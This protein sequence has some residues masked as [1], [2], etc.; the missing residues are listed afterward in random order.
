MNRHLFL[1]IVLLFC[2]STL[3]AQEKQG[4][5]SGHIR[6]GQGPLVGA[7]AFLIKDQSTQEIFRYAISDS[8]GKFSITIPEGDYIL[9][10]SFVGYD[11][12]VKEI[13][14]TSEKLDVGSITLQETT[15]ELQ[16][17]VVRGKAVKVR[18]QP[19]G[20]VVNVKELRERSNDALDLLKLIPRVQ[21]K[22]DQLSVIG[23]D[24]V[25]VKVGNVLQ[26]VEAS[27]IASVLKGYDA[28]LI[29][30]VEVI[31]QPP[32]RYDPDGN[33]AMI[34][35]HTSSIF[36]EYIG[37]VVGTEEMWGGK[38]NFRFGGHGALHYNRRGLFASLAPSIN[39]NGS[40]YS[41]QQ[42]YQMGKY[43]YKVQTPSVG[44]FNYKGIRGNLQ[45][46]YG[47]KK[48]IGWAFSWNGK[49]YNN[50]FE[51]REISS[52]LGDF[53]RV[54]DNENS[55]KS[56]EP[57]LTATAYWE[58]TFGRKGHQVWTE[59][60]YFNLTNGSQTNYVGRELFQNT[61]FLKY[62][63]DNDINTSGLNLNNDYSIYIDSEHKYLLET[64]IKGAWSFTTNYR[65]H[66]E[67]RNLNPATLQS[68]SIRWN[69]LILTPYISSTLR[70]G[71][72]WWMR[73]GL[74]YTGTQSLLQQIG[75]NPT[76]IPKVSMYHDAWLPLL[77]TSYTPSSGH[78][79]TFSFN[80]SIDRP[81]FKDLNPFVWQINENSFYRGNTDLRPQLYY[82]TSLGYTFKRAL[83]IKGRA[84]RGLGLITT[85]S[86]MQEKKIYT[87]M[88]NAQNSLFL[89]LEAGYYLDK[90]SWMSAGIDG[91]YGWSQYTSTH[92]SL[93]PETQ[94]REWGLSGYLDITFNKNRTWTGYI[95]GEYT[96]RKNTTVA[97]I[98]PQYDL[99]IGMSYFL[100][101]RRLSL[102]V[103]GLN[104]IS[105]AYKGVSHRA[106][107][108]IS[109]NNRYS[110]PTLYLSISYKFSNAKDRTN[111]R[112]KGA[113]E[114]EHRF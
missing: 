67:H 84:K 27:E 69:E 74:K 70:F 28:G 65:T 78:Q 109:F 17:V 107:Y 6:D 68:N 42:E 26:R 73:L 71:E 9:G 103:A 50:Q 61:P 57:R 111:T 18:T 114:I 96:G 80:S 10:V 62:S 85:L 1:F 16:T 95:S 56:S 4:V 90:L 60:S 97:S 32:L 22:G 21:V 93:L 87:Q 86:T 25:L 41:E 47:D 24:K 53:E 7:S 100:L 92:Q 31:T 82:I 59:L 106:G 2:A 104:L 13:H 88:E 101:N 29:D 79:I 66:T 11:L 38:D 19:D 35:L 110:Y 108:S 12:Y 77:H 45:Y 91:Y 105:S 83:S 52:Q 43:Q 64:G 20:F 89:G 75:K 23:K 40:E 51:S 55:Y 39:F 30:R 81:K 94:G 3:F 37:G 46:E 54:V 49:K 15:K 112:S 63:E 36:K 34:I 5:V 99:G 58:T 102:S 44:Q 76:G 8:N 72:R 14:I 33:T 98:E 113:Q 48:L